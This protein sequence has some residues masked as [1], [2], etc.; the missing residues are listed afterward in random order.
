MRITS[1][2]SFY[3]R[4]MGLLNRKD[5]SQDEGIYFPRCNAVHTCFMRFPIMVVFCRSGK[6]VQCH[7]YVKPWRFLRCATADSV[8]EFAAYRKAGDSKRQTNKEHSSSKQIVE[9]MS[10]QLYQEVQVIID[11]FFLA[12]E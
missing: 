11:D 1:A 8:F 7:P 6:V 3:Q 12:S 10:F 9:P 5:L 2:I 4:L